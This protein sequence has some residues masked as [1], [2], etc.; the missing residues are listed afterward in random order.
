MHKPLL[1]LFTAALISLSANAQFEGPS[2]QVLISVKQIE[3]LSDDT[4][5]VLEGR[6]VKKLKNENYLFEDQSGSITVEID[7]E[8]FKGMKVTPDNVVRIEG[9]VETSLTKPT[10]VEVDRITVIK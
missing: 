1:A 3:Q 8:D 6:L 2:D 10:T 7:D 9:E 4:D 5:V